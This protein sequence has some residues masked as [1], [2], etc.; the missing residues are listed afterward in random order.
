MGECEWIKR[1]TKENR[2]KYNVT[3]RRLAVVQPEHRPQ[4]ELAAPGME[5]PVL[6]PLL[7]LALLFLVY[8][9]VRRVKGVRR[10]AHASHALA[11]RGSVHPGLRN[12]MVAHLD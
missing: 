8:F 5:S 1:D 11:R 4:P 10:N 2:E 7:L 6:M 12:V 9:V 3:R